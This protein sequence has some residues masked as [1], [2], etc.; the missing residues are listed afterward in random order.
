MYTQF[1]HDKELFGIFGGISEFLFI[2][3]FHD[4]LQNPRRCFKERWLGNT[5]LDIGIIRWHRSV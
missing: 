5:D 4:I 1:F 2:Y 3:L